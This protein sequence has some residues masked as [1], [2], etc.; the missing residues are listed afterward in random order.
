MFSHNKL[1][2]PL[3]AK[4]NSF[5]IELLLTFLKT[6]SLTFLNC[7]MVNGWQWMLVHYCSLFTFVYTT[8]WFLLNSWKIS[9]S[10]PNCNLNVLLHH[11]KQLETKPPPP[12]SMWGAKTNEL[13]WIALWCCL[14]TD[15]T[16]WAGHSALNDQVGEVI[17]NNDDFNA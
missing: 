12:V 2:L 13:T 15:W 10:R 17:Q 1:Y 16:T 9:R 6:V 7:S 3:F 11:N 8:K 14:W 4:P 5:K